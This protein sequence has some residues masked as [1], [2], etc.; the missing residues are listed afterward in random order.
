MSRQQK[1]VTTMALLTAEQAAKRLGR[2]ERTVR[3]WIAEQR[4]PATHPIHGHTSKFLIDESDVERLPKELAQDEQQQSDQDTS[5]LAQRFNQ[6]EQEFRDYR[7]SSGTDYP[8]TDTV[9]VTHL[10]TRLEALEQSFKDYQA[11]TEV[12]LEA[13]ERAILSVGT[14]EQRASSTDKILRPKRA[15]YTTET[16]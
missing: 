16:T 11:Q 7:L 12:R 14:P 6:L 10:E 1:G 3:R 8:S 15:T 9:Y 5:E 4:L 13:L 2:T